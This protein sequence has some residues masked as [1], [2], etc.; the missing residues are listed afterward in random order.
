MGS[1]STIF[2]LFPVKVQSIKFVNIFLH[3]IMCFCLLEEWQKMR[4]QS[5]CTKHAFIDQA[6]SEI[7]FNKY[8]TVFSFPMYG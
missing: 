5:F 4:K 8:V 7:N 2:I 6:I 3:I 1:V